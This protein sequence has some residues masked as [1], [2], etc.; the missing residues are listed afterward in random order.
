MIFARLAVL[1]F[2]LVIPALISV[3]AA[4]ES[5]II[6]GSDMQPIEFPSYIKHMS[7]LSL[8]KEIPSTVTGSVNSDDLILL[9]QM[10]I[11]IGRTARTTEGT[12]IDPSNI[13]KNTLFPNEKI[14]RIIQEYLQQ[15]TTADI[16]RLLPIAFDLQIKPLYNNLAYCLARR[17]ISEKKNLAEMKLR[18]ELLPYI[19]K[20]LRLL[21][22]GFVE[23]T[24]KDEIALH[25]S[26]E[27]LE[28]PHKLHGPDRY[29]H[30]SNK[31]L[32]SLEGIELIEPT[33]IIYIAL[34]GNRLLNCIED[35]DFPRRPLKRFMHLQ[36]LD[37]SATSLLPLTID[38]F[39][40]LDHLRY[41]NLFRSKIELTNETFSNLKHLKKLHMQ[42]MGLTRLPD[43]LLK[44]LSDLEELELKE[45]HLKTLPKTLLDSCSKLEK[46]DLADNQLQQLPAEF[47]RN[48]KDLHH[49]I[50]RNNQ[51]TQLPA[52]LFENQK[53]VTLLDVSYNQ[54][55]QLENNTVSELEKLDWLFL[56]NN[57]LSTLGDKA[58]KS[59]KKLTWLRLDNNQLTTLPKS[60]FDNLSNLITLS[61]NHNQIRTIDKDG[62][63]ALGK[64][65]TLNLGFNQISTLSPGFL[66]YFSALQM[67]YLNHNQI[68]TLPDGLLINT[69][70]INCIYLENNALRELPEDIFRSNPLV[71][72]HLWNNYLKLNTM[73]NFRKKYNKP[74]NYR[75][76]LYLFPQKVS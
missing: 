46:I 54:L 25:G 64:L 11:D 69:P 23:K 22:F 28:Y 21:K 3:H 29:L 71:I 31:Q 8:P 5:I 18:T 65:E 56:N 76:D 7:V 67:L 9:K 68:T 14:R 4:S 1:I 70:H 50:L 33:G 75:N 15:K 61:L 43:Y 2:L 48:G 30:L 32:T 49:V 24:I 12:S 66:G 17:Y 55:S 42:K 26:P 41:L 63:M 10:C 74:V 45:N 72:I 51:L 19:K 20:H 57:N 35:P 44:E 6:R 34:G 39:E 16:E 36:S 58:F 13:N 62:F 73:D 40:G 47:F 38:V 59:L 37:L 27:I 53:K 52:G 60:V